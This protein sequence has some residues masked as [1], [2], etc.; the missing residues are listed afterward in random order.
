MTP[1]SSTP[2]VIPGLDEVIPWKATQPKPKHCKAQIAKP[3]R[4]NPQ[5]LADTISLAEKPDKTHSEKMKLARYY[6][7]WRSLGHTP[8][9][10][11]VPVALR[12][13]YHDSRDTMQLRALTA[14]LIHEQ[15]TATLSAGNK[16]F[17]ERIQAIWS[18]LEKHT[19]AA[20]KIA[21]A[22]AAGKIATDAAAEAAH[23]IDVAESM[24][25]VIADRLRKSTVTREDA[26]VILPYAK[27]N[28]E[29]IKKLDEPID[30]LNKL[31]SENVK[32]LEQIINASQ[33]A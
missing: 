9:K 6:D 24:A 2:T 14:K 20:R 13:T 21:A 1:V 19:A 18:D 31:A 10:L 7:I 32:K 33:P 28:Q 27:E 16:I 29:N 5:L 3:M 25:R 15:Q 11:V 26:V 4:D 17:L 22:E 30:E 12:P 23:K 8:E